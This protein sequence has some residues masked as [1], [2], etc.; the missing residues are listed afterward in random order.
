M[1]GIT[2]KEKD[3]LKETAKN[4][5]GSNRRI[6][7]AQVA[8]K[9]GYGGISFAARNLH[10]CRAT[11]QKGKTELRDGPIED[12]FSG[13]GRNKSEVNHPNLLDDIKKIVEPESQ[14]DPSFRSCRIYTRL[15]AKEVRKRL[16]NMGYDDE[17]LPCVRTINTKLNDLDYKL[18]KVQ[19]TKPQKKNQRNE[20]NL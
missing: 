17:T 8:E 19:K 7:M 4:L 11:I 1:L 9:F 20:R 3:W 18:K 2:D 12:N 10:W 13:R 5:K 16:L 15:T 6:F 14:T